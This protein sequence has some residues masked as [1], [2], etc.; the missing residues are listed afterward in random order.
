MTNGSLMKVE[1]IKKIAK[2]FGLLFE[3]PFKTEF[4][5]LKI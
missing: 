4:T 1:R 3:W 5:V 2:K